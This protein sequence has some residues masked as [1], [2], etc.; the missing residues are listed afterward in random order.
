MSKKIT[1]KE[2]EQAKNSLI[3]SALIWS[4][5]IRYIVVTEEISK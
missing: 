2:K 1:E 4:I 5:N 3:D